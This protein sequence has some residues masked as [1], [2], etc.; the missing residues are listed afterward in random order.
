MPGNGRQWHQVGIVAAPDL[1]IQ[2]IDG[3]CV[4]PDQDLSRLRDRL[5]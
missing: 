2:R 4:Y 5:S 1:E 3:G